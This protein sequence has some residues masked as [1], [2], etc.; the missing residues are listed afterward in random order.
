MST[1][2][3]CYLTWADGAGPQQFVFDLVEMESWQDGAEATKHP[4]E[5]GPDVSDHVRVSLTRVSMKIKATNHPV[6][7]NQF[8]QAVQ[9]ANPLQVPTPSWIPGSG[10]LT[11]KEWQS[12]LLARTLALSAGGYAAGALG[13]PV[14]SAVTAVAGGLLAGALIPG[15]AVDVPVVTDAGLLPPRPQPT[16]IA[17][18]LSFTDSDDFVKR[19]IAQ[20]LA[21]KDAAQLIDVIGTKQEC[22]SMVITHVETHRSKETGTGAQIDLTL[23]QIRI[24]ETTTVPAPAP[25]VVAGKPKVS[26]GNQNTSDASPAIAHSAAI[27]AGAGDFLGVR[28]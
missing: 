18:T 24:V 25:S 23:E 6:G 5:D 27:D 10:I 4:V 16:V 3:S 13:G 7:T 11:V 12:N 8:A 22:S 2:T 15:V 17:T 28:P 20:L 1:P 19:T 9:G 14:A 21:L 26:K